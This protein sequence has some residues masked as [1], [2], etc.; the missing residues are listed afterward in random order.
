M[1]QVQTGPPGREGE[2]LKILDVSCHVVCRIA[3][4]HQEQQRQKF[5]DG[6]LVLVAIGNAGVG[7]SSGIQAE[8][9]VIVCDDH[10]LLREG[11]PEVVFVLGT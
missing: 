9:I 6:V 8:E 7:G 5:A 1:L 3:R 4:I 10:S 2:G 11:V